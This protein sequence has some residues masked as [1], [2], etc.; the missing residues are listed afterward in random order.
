[1]MKLMIQ[2]WLFFNFLIVL[3]SWD[4]HSEPSYMGKETGR[5]ISIFADTK[6]SNGGV[7]LELATVHIFLLQEADSQYGK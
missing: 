1:M 4:F 7:V 6:H 3:H 5:E 2:L